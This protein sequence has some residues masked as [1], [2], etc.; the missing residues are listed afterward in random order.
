MLSNI[1][2]ANCWTATVTWGCDLCASHLRYWV[3]PCNSFYRTW[4]LREAVIR[5]VVLLLL[6]KH[7]TWFTDRNNKC[8]C[9]ICAWK[10]IL[11]EKQARRLLRW[12]KAV[13]LRVQ[14]WPMQSFLDKR[15]RNRNRSSPSVGK[16]LMKS[17]SGLS[18]LLGKSSTV[19]YRIRRFQ[20]ST[21]LHF[22][23]RNSTR[24][25]ERFTE[26]QGTDA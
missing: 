12:F 10:V 14:K 19:L 13:K 3:C 26:V 6:S 22:Q 4:F 16:N 9:T 8:P 23:R 21:L 17:K 18:S 5:S 24:E 7:Y 11:W 25:S 20:V 15:K 2:S 1:T